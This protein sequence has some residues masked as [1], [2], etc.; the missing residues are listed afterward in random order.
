MA[1]TIEDLEEDDGQQDEGFTE[2]TDEPELPME[3]EEEKEESEMKPSS[4]LQL[5]LTSI[6]EERGRSVSHQLI[7]DDGERT[8]HYLFPEKGGVAICH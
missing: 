7:T 1:S 4:S 3:V 8:C 5:M 2:E 6:A